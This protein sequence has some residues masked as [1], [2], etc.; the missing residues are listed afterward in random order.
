MKEE[1]WSIRK[2]REQQKLSQSRNTYRNSDY[3]ENEDVIE[4]VRKKREN[5]FLSIYERFQIF[6]EE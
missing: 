2:M 1:L 4:N 3:I 6:L 5:V